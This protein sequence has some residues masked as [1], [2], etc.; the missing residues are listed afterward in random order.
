MCGG[1]PVVLNLC[2]VDERNPCE[3]PR[4][5]TLAC[6]LL[7]CAGADLR[8]HAVFALRNL[9]HGNAENQAFVD[10]IK[11]AGEWDEE[12]VLRD[13]PGAIRR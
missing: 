8:E 1:I 11:P 12:G 7:T 4:R 9:L 10:G 5:R 3:C 2:V 6:A 13:T